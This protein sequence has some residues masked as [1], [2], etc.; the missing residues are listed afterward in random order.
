MSV[1]DSLPRPEYP[2]PQLRRDRWTSLNGT[3]AFG[4]DDTD[5]GR[6][7]GWHTV[8]AAALAERNGPFDRTIVVPFCPQAKLSGI[9]E[10]DRHDVVW[11]ARMLRRPADAAPDDRIL[12]HFGA[13][14]YHA[15]VWIDG[16]LVAEHRGGHTPFHADITEPLSGGGDHVLVVRA[17]DPLDDLAMPRG[18][19]Y[20]RNESEGIF[21]TPT[22]GIWQSVWLEPVPR[23]HIAEL[24]FTP[25]VPSGRLDMEITFARPVA[26][27]TVEITASL[28]GQ[29]VARDVV[30][31]DGPAL[32]HPLQLGRCGATPPH[33]HIGEWPGVALWSPENPQLYDLVVALRD[34]DG[35]I[36]D[37]VE[38]YAGMRSIAV[39]N[40]KVLLNGLPYIQRLVL[41][42]GYFPDGL[43]TAPTDDD[44]RRD[45]ELAKA[46]GF[47]GARK[48]Q[49]IE[50]PRWLYWADRLGFLVWGEMANAYAH[51][52]DYVHRIT[53]EWT[54]ALRRDHN[55]PCV[56][57]WVPMNE[58]WGVPHL[59]TDARQ[60]A[61]LRAM[62]HLTKTLDTSRLVVSNDGWE[63]A[64][65]DL[66]T[67]HDYRGAD[68]LR[69]G[70]SSVE[71][72]LTGEP[73]RR[74]A[75]VVDAA[76]QGQPLLVTEFGGVS[77][78]GDTDGW[79]YSSVEDGEELLRRYA[80]MVDAVASSPVLRGF[81]WT[82]LT[83][84]EQEVNGLLRADR[85]P[86]VDLERIREATLAAR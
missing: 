59:R 16:H 75:L 84:V 70:Y 40:G 74:P 52:R 4:Y 85:T 8:T 35:A 18:K 17:A 13:V 7:A 81:C 3:W 10:R 49:K 54:E 77:F 15:T 65:T 53:A 66:V 33:P 69:A 31:V 30:D 44:L 26:G 76:Y 21:Y 73:A 67:L 19:Q 42:Q 36:V 37:R 32:A 12:L 25:D 50:D 27:M 34:V 64:D 9:G 80:A 23:S 29:Q 51:S 20:W 45:I 46:M 43:M 55:H 86:K 63:H 38:S 68:Q 2:R 57:V 56:V 72:A 62:Y 60:R 58:S 39:R 28:D 1:S 79:G 83:D 61:H 78:T 22:T 48:H 14:D 5:I 41:D 47:N 82:Q 24:L 6:D 11:Y 71:A